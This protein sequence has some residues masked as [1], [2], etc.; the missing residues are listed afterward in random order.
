[1]PVPLPRPRTIGLTAT[2]EYG[3]LT[4]RVRGLVGNNVEEEKIEWEG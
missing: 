3:M 1:M 2:A 4:L